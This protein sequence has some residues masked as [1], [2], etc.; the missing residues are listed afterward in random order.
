MADASGDTKG[1]PVSFET[2][3]TRNSH[4]LAINI[5]LYFQQFYREYIHSYTAAPH[6][7]GR[8]TNINN[9]SAA[10]GSRFFVDFHLFAKLCV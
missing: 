10:V 2:V 4:F 5:Y 7:G 8:Q 9:G 1:N 3:Q 6:F